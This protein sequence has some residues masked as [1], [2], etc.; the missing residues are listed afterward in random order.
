MYWILNVLED[1]HPVKICFSDR[2]SAEDF[3]LLINTYEDDSGAGNGYSAYWPDYKKRKILPH[4]WR[5]AESTAEIDVGHVR[6][7]LWSIYAAHAA[8]LPGDADDLFSV[9]TAGDALAFSLKELPPR[10]RPVVGE[11]YRIPRSLSG[12]AHQR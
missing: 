11:M 1:A 7:M 10:V 6:W 12:H 3:S 2:R 8:E 5:P 9:A 4:F